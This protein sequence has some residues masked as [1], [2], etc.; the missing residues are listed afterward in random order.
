VGKGRRKEL[1]KTA[2]ATLAERALGIGEV[3]EALGIEPEE[4]VV[5]MRELRGRRRGK[6]VSSLH[7]G[8]TVWRWEEVPKSA[9]PAKPKKGK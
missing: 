4:V 8:H 5:V 9:R 6:L 1:A 2:R 7:G 3:A